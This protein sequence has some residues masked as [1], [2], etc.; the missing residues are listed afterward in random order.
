MVVVALVVV[1][2]GDVVASI[3][4]LRY[5]ELHYI[6]SSLTHELPMFKHFTSN[7]YERFHL[8]MM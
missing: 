8:F 7:M 6:T 1:I 3:A 2:S 5:R 4:I